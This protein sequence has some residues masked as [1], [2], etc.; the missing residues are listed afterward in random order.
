[1]TVVAIHQPNYLPWLGFFGKALDSDVLILYD[2]VQFEKGG[3]TN[4]VR[5]KGKAGAE[6]LTQPVATAGRGFQEI[7]QV[8]FARSDWQVK[9][10]RALEANYARAAYFKP[11]FAQLTDLL[12]ASGTNL[13][14]YNERLT[15]WVCNVLQ[16]GVV[17]VRASDL[18][19]EESDPTQRLI[20]L[21]L[22][23]G[24]D[25]YLSGSGGFAYQNL[26]AFERAGLRVMRS[27]SNFPEYA[28]LWGE[29]CPG[30]SILDLLFNCGPASRSL[31][32]EG[33][34]ND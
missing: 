34:W 24:G 30:L 21:V 27:R 31:L 6:W 11:C 23:V 16:L 15:R 2:T 7:R 22:A 12:S 3:F 33:T 18:A 20:A 10:L 26:E 9:H 5:I 13:S 28:Q 4:R 19:T 14:R 17:L 25:T 8:M 29:F 32:E 1:M